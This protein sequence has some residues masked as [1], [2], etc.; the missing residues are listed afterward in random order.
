M[1]PESNDASPRPN[2]IFDFFNKYLFTVSAPINIS[3]A[4]MKNAAMPATTTANMLPIVTAGLCARAGA[5][6]HK[7]V[8]VI[9]IRYVQ[10][11]LAFIIV[12][13]FG[14]TT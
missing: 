14:I 10:K 2:F 5:T 6:T 8:A 3:T 13:L 11:I 1:I 9:A 12:S 4:P 7:R